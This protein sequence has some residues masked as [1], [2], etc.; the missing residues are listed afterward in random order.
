MSW[1]TDNKDSAPWAL[2]KKDWSGDKSLI[3]IPKSA[4]NNQYN[5]GH[6]ITTLGEPVWTLD[7]SGVAIT[8]GHDPCGIW[9]SNLIAP[10]VCDDSGMAWD[11]ETSAET[12]AQNNS[13]TVAITDSLGL[14]MPYTWEVSGSG[15]TL[16]NRETSG[17]VNILNADSASC[18][19]ATITV[20]GCGGN[21][22]TGFVRGTVG[23]W[24]FQGNIIGLQGLA[25]T[26]TQSGSRYRCYKILGNKRQ[27]QEILLFYTW[28][29]D[30]EGIPISYWC[31]HYG[32]DGSQCLSFLRPDHSKPYPEG[33][34]LISDLV[35][36]PPCTMQSGIIKYSWDPDPFGC[37][38]Y[39]TTSLRYY[40]WEC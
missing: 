33:E 29:K 15:F 7:Q 11:S 28:F 3:D 1:I 23:R 21:K 34:W 22:I 13:C 4:A 24:K 37:F 12:V 10:S 17:L 6:K 14:G 38:Y 26:V 31:S 19:A 40:L 5:E 25:D 39:V 16:D 9:C 2:V 8:D 32:Y 20:T 18:G 36:Y 27:Y 30:C 35:D